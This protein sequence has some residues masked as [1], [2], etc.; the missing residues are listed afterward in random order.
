MEAPMVAKVD[1]TGRQF[2]EMTV[3]AAAESD[4]HGKAR[5]LCR[6]SCGAEKVVN[7]SALRAGLT[8]SCGGSHHRPDI[9][10]HGHARIGAQTSEYRSWAN[11]IQR[12]TNPS[13][14]DYPKYGG[15][16][17][18]VCDRWLSFDNFLADMG[19]KPSSAYTIDRKDN[20]RGYEPANCRWATRREQVL[21]RA[22]T[23]MTDRIAANI[24]ASKR[25]H[26][27]LAEEYGVS[28]STIAA[29]RSGRNWKEVQ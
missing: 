10:V 25:S 9:A 24:R 18:L 8:K 3:I 12:C 1:F 16:G 20:S 17:I 4:R 26:A 14:K 21:N 28:K 22:Y 7:A 5:W 2:G 27:S 6:C 15:R 19:C 29:I 23:Q 11:M 13:C